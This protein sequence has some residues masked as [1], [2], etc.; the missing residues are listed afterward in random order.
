M[1]KTGDLTAADT[2]LEQIYDS[3]RAIAA[4]PRRGRPKPEFGRGLRSHLVGKYVVFYRPHRTFVEITRVIHQRR[5]LRRAFAKPERRRVELT[6]EFRRGVWERVDSGRY[7]STADV[8]RAWLEA[9]AAQEAYDDHT[10]A[11]RREIQIGIDQVERGEVVDGE[12]SYARLRQ[13]IAERAAEH[14][15]EADSGGTEPAA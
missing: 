9:L 2:L 6:P 1:K 7:A 15:R 3:F 11:H 10:E 12:V 5:N 14:A 13:Q 4:M 8:L